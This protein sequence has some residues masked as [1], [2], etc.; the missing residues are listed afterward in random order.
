M[1]GEAFGV[2]ITLSEHRELRVMEEAIVAVITKES[3][4]DRPLIEMSGLFGVS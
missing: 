4:L 3:L 1:D 2:D